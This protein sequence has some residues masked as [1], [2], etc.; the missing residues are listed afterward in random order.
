MA[1]GKAC[2]AYR[3]NQEI[4]YVNRSYGM[5]ASAEVIIEREPN[6]L[7]IPIRASFVQNDKPAVYVQRGDQFLVRGIAV[8]KR[9]EEDMVVLSGLREGELVTLENPAEAAKRA[10][11]KL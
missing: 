5:S 11:K 7:L 3:Y 4:L 1:F 2:C 8:G 10:K 6:A 9:N